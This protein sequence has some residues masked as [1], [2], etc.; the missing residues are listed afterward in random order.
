MF[1]NAPL[2]NLTYKLA[3]YKKILCYINIMIQKLTF[4]F[5]TALKHVPKLQDHFTRMPYKQQCCV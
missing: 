5:C 3:Q 1:M 2:E 4:G